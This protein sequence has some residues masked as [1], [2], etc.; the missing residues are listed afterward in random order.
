MTRHARKARNFLK[1]ENRVSW[2][3]QTLWMVR[4]KRDKIAHTVPEWEQLRE[5]ASRIK[6]HTLSNI[7]NYLGSAEKPY[8][9]FT[10]L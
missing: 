1:N 5:Q 8:A 3:D 9:T 4:H 2:H 6:Q 7:D 10:I